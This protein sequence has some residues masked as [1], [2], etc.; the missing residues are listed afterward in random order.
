MDNGD[1]L[2]DYKSYADSLADSM[3]QANQHAKDVSDSFKIISD[4]SIEV[5]ENQEELNKTE[6]NRLNR[7]EKRREIQN[8]ITST[9]LDQS[10]QLS[11]MQKIKKATK[12]LLENEADLTKKQYEKI[13]EQL[14]KRYDEQLVL[15]AQAEVQEKQ[16]KLTDVLNN[17]TDEFLDSIESSIKSIPIIGNL[18][19]T[20]FDFD[21]I[22]EDFKENILSNMKNGISGLGTGVK[23]FGKLFL[24]SLLP[25]LP[26]VAVITA[27]KTAFDFDEKVTKL[28][29]ELGISKDAAMDMQLSFKSISDS[30]NNLMTSEIAEAQMQLAESTGMTA[31]FS[32][33]MLKSQAELT[34][35][36][37][38]SGDEAANLNKFTQSIGSDAESLKMEVA[39]VVEQF[40][41]GTG[42]SISM[43]D[44]L[45][46]IAGLSATMKANFKGNVT[47][48]TKALTLAKAM[49][50]SLEA[51]SSAAEKTLSI[52]SSLKSELT[53]QLAAGVKIN[54]SEIRRAQL[55]GDQGKVIELQRK[56]LEEIGDIS[57]MMPRQREAIANAM[58]M[59][60]SQLDEMK[61]TM[62]LNK[63]LNM[64]LSDATIQDINNAKGLSEEKKKQLIAD[65]QRISAQEKMNMATE[66]LQEIFINIAPVLIGIV[67]IFSSIVG[68]IGNMI[69]GI[70]E[71]KILL[72]ALVITLAPLAVSLITSAI[73]A[74]FT[75]FGLL[76]PLGPPLA[77]VAVAGMMTQLA[78]AKKVGDVMSPAD[79]KTT[80]STKEG[81]LFELSPNDDLVAAPGLIGGGGMNFG[82]L[83]NE[84]KGLRR[85]IQTQPIMMTVDGKVVS[86][87][88]KVQNQQNSI[89][90]SGYGR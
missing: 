41:E 55:M 66:K 22:K 5:L 32:D 53:A 73:G 57:E 11:E 20:S 39:G 42:A 49:G 17:K 36:F 12:I 80:V 79:G 44:I 83:I 60:L 8:D 23:S 7:L 46:D 28:S 14:Q 16:N 33:D 81:G 26:I 19:A 63:A 78:S 89:N 65:K 50:T 86:A 70:S 31:K 59:E 68:F 75:G 45:K 69:T 74:I 43:K 2:K 35:F 67:D 87:I 15:E 48:M 71:S 61:E 29:R 24:K 30:T 51:S 27:L 76:G 37:G 21:K 54:N 25:I 77:L 72:S 13:S 47:E 3:R 4:K 52:E 6:Q 62:E 64:D 1:E 85:D 84:I 58:G 9:L 34:K 82:E 56:Q 90:T 18:L 10:Q 88:T 38:L 40:N